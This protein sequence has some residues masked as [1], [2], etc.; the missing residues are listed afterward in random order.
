MLSYQEPTGPQLLEYL[1]VATVWASSEA[2][3]HYKTYNEG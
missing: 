1:S 3:G 2:L